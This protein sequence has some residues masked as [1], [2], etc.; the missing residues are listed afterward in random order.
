MMTLDYQLGP[1]DLLAFSEEHRRFMPDFPSHLYYYGVLPALFVA[2]AVVTQSLAI[3][4]V[5]AVLYLSSAWLVRLWAHKRY[6]HAAYSPDN[7]SIQ[8]LPRRVTLSG[9]GV[10]FSSD[11]GVLLY[12]WPFIRRVLRGTSYIIFELTPLERLHIPIRAFRDDNHIQEFLK[13]AKLHVKSSAA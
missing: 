6:Y 2:L 1:A 7:I 13:E 8:T 5:F 12:R 4:T 11:V 3:A 10:N 9:D